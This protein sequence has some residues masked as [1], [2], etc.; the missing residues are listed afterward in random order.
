MIILPPQAL[1]AFEDA[2][3]QTTSPVIVDGSDAAAHR[4]Y[5]PVGALGSLRLHN[6]PPAPAPPRV[7]VLLAHAQSVPLTR[8]LVGRLSATRSA[9]V[10]ARAWRECC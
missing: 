9:D 3:L 10:R 1:V 5:G 6:A 2:R 8:N 4:H 7:G